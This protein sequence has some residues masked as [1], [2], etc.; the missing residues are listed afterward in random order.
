[1]TATIIQFPTL[2]ERDAREFDRFG[3]S[4]YTRVMDE[5]A[6]LLPAIWSRRDRAAHSRRVDAFARQFELLARGRPEMVEELVMLDDGGMI[7]LRAV[8]AL[9]AA[10]RDAA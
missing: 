10:R 5:A 1:M 4:T 3:T 8:P 7:E 2:E 9:L 6:A